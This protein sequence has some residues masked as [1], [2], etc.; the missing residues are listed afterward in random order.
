MKGVEC[1]KKILF[2]LV[3][4]FILGIIV[5]KAQTTKL[6]V[7]PASVID[8]GLTPGNTFTVYIKVSDVENLYGYDF[9]LGYDTTILD[10]TATHTPP[11]IWGSNYLTIL[12]NV[13]E[14]NG[15]YSLVVAAMSPAPSF[16]GSTSLVTLDFTVTGYGESVLDIY[17]SGLSD[18]GSPA[19]PIPHDVE[20]GYFRNSETITCYSDLDCDDGNECTHDDCLNPGTPES[21]C[22][23]PNEPD[24][25]SCSGSPGR[26]C[27]GVCDNDG[28][29]GTDYH[30]NCR[31]GPQCLGAGDWGYS[32]ANQGGNCGP[33]YGHECF[34]QVSC[35]GRYYYDSCNSGYCSGSPNQIEDD[36]QCDGQDC[37]ICCVCS[38]GTRI[39]DGTQNSDCNPFDIAT[40]FNVPDNYDFTWDYRDS[41]CIALDTCSQDITHTCADD[42]LDD[43]IPLGG[44]GAGCDEDSD[45]ASGVCRND[46]TCAPVSAFDIT[47]ISPESKNYS[48]EAVWLNVTADIPVDTWEYDL[49]SGGRQTFTPYTVIPVDQC[50]NDLTVY[51]TSGED[52]GFDSVQFNALVGDSLGDGDVDI[53]DVVHCADVYGSV[54]G[55][56][57]YRQERGMAEPPDG[58]GDIDIYD[59]VAMA[60]NYGKRC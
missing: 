51:A 13:D 39:F 22:D 47:I 54:E 44:C 31:S 7:D 9:R 52:E 48:V 59:I 11:S 41:Q 6:F 57:E 50:F 18:N 10:L 37:G 56:G 5:V 45:C 38:S 35:D 24:G 55:D 34:N 19:R 21:Y 60:D 30:V 53:Y 4:S 2:V 16:N 14:T 17:D 23:N 42:D 28:T 25:T 27:S 46:C 36:S 40:C 33:A 58:D 3:I 15:I 8:L 26:C 20:D 32:T 1:M 12:N 43:T 49:N 29:S